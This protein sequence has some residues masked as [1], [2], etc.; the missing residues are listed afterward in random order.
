MPLIRYILIGIIGY[1]I[2]RSFIKFGKAGNPSSKIRQPEKQD[3]I[4]AKKVSRKT[5]EY[6]DYEETKK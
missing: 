2:I 4:P 3:K 1:L 5:G 6:I